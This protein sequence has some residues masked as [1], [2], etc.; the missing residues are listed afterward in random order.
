MGRTVWMLAMNV[1]MGHPGSFSSIRRTRLAPA[2]FQYPARRARPSEVPSDS[3]DHPSTARVPSVPP[4]VV[5]APPSWVRPF[6]VSDMRLRG[7][8]VVVGAQKDGKS[9]LVKHLLHL[10]RCHRR[11]PTLCVVAHPGEHAYDD[12]GI[13]GIEGIDGIDMRLFKGE[14]GAQALDQARSFMS[15]TRGVAAFDDCIHVTVSQRALYECLTDPSMRD[16]LRIVA[17]SFPMSPPPEVDYVIMLRAASLSFRRRLYELHVRD[18]FPSFE[19]FDQVMDALT[20]SGDGHRAMVVD[21]RADDALPLR[22]RV[23]FL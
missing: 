4:H 2:H 6:A 15:R 17:M 11:V 13:E 19:A 16:T 5:V 10:L 23:S 18:S 9:T 1:A 3:E 21:V 8:V 14:D 20:A 12:G 22:Q 7:T